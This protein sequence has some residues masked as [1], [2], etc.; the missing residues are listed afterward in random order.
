ME[1]KIKKVNNVNVVYPPARVD[2]DKCRVLGETLE[3]LINKDVSA[4]LLLN[5]N[6]VDHL[7]STGLSVILQSLKMLNDSNRKL[8]LCM[9]NENVQRVLR[10]VDLNSFVEV[11]ETEEDALESFIIKQAISTN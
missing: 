3:D 6:D 4:H 2:F 10:I 5:F 9:V 8:K 11:M 7:N 1:I